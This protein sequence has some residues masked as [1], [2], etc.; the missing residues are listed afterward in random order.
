MRRA[1]HGSLVGL[2]ALG[3][4]PWPPTV[5]RVA[6]EPSPDFATVVRSPGEGARAR[7]AESMLSVEEARQLAGGL[8]D[9]LRAIE[10]LPGVGRASL[11][12][13]SLLLWGAAPGDSRVIYLGMEL[14]S[15]YHASGLRGA[16]PAA[17]LS[18][19][20]LVPA[21]FGAEYGRA[22]GGLVLLGPRALP[23][24]WHGELAA[25]LLD[26]SAM[27]SGA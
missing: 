7:P 12:A 26:V 19:V 18:S 1:R 27:L 23:D 16:L 6:A 10:S 2:V 24:G 21:G 14:P 22:L 3:W 25:D 17:L 15:L 11:G 20:R 13:G 4:L 8:G 5:G 9:P